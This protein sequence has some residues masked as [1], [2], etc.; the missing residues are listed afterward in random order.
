MGV[1]A[2]LQRASTKRILIEF[3]E[4]L[5]ERT[6]A[7]AEELSTDRSKL[8]RSA[9]ENFLESMEQQRI[10][11]ELEEAYAANANFA[12]L[13]CDDLAHLDGDAI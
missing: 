2:A 1:A 4:N 7:A 3:P 5:L 12:L 11:R 13:V 6:E 9:V 8:I 10:Q